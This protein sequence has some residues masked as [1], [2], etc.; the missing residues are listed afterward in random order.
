M[1]C[2]HLAQERVHSCVSFRIC[3][4]S[5]NFGF[6]QRNIFIHNNFS[7]QQTNQ[8]I[9]N[10]GIF[11]TFFLYPPKENYLFYFLQFLSYRGMSQ[12]LIFAVHIYFFKMLVWYISRAW[13][14]SYYVLHRLI[15]TLWNSIFIITLSIHWQLWDFV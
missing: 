11:Y 15:G 12:L 13:H 1:D 2:K 3:T 14:W 4:N 6:Q 7:L 5:H 10:S 8:K 9:Q